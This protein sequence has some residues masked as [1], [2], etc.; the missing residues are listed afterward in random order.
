VN[1]FNCAFVSDIHSCQVH[2]VI[3]KFN[4]SVLQS[5][6]SK[7]KCLLISRDSSESGIPVGRV[8]FDALSTPRTT[9]NV[10]AILCSI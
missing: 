4:V 3:I 1:N 10:A 5:E 6:I 7:P 9:L 8:S 2:I